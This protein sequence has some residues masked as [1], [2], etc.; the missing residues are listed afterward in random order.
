MLNTKSLHN[1]TPSSTENPKALVS[2]V[3]RSYSHIQLQKI[4]YNHPRN[5]ISD[6]TIATMKR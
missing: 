1:I 2:K 3:A 4:I 5:G 6:E